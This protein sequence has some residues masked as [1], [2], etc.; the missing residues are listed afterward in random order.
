[1]STL[2]A[3]TRDQVEALVRSIIQ[4]QLCRRRRANGHAG[5]NGRAARELA[6]RWSSTSRRGTA[7]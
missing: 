4:R 6:P 7:I 2:A 5:G 3:P 1:M